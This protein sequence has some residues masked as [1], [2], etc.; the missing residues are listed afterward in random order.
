[1]GVCGTGGWTGPLPGDPDSVATLSAV[2][3]F[4]GVE[5][6]WTM[7]GTNPHAVSYTEV[8]RSTSSNFGDAVLLGTSGGGSYFDRLQNGQTHWYWIRFV[9]INGTTGD[10]IGPA[11][12]MSGLLVDNL[13]AALLGQITSGQFSA[14]I[15]AEMDKIALIQ[16]DLAAEIANRLAAFEALQLVL[17]GLQSE[18]LTYTDLINGE[19]IDRI[20]ADA[21]ILNEV[22]Q[23]IDNAKAITDA[24]IQAVQD[25]INDL[26]G[27][28]GAYDELVTYSIGQTVTYMGS[29]YRAIAE[30]TGNLPTDTAYWQKIGDYA[31]LGEVVAA[32][33][34]TLND[35]ETR[36]EDT[37]DGLVATATSLDALS[38]QVRG[39]YTGNDL[40]AVSAG[41]IFQEREARS[42]AVSTEV[43]AR[44]ALSATITGV[45]NPTGL[46][47]GTLASGLLYDERNARVTADEA[48]VDR[49]D[50]LEATVNNPTTGVVATADALDTVELT[51]NNGTTGVVATA[52]KVSILE[53]KIDNPTVGNNPTYALLV[54]NY[55]S[56][57]DTNSAIA[58]AVN[59]VVANLN[60]AG[61][62]PYTSIAQTRTVAESKSATFTQSST[63]TATKVGDLW[64]DTGN[65][66]ILKR[67]NGSSWVAADDTR[68]GATA[69]SVQQ[70]QAQVGSTDVIALQ[71]QAN[72]NANDIT[73]LEGKYTVKIDANGY[74]TG[75]GLAVNANN[76]TPT[77]EF[78]VKADQFTIAPVQTDNTANDGS[79]FFYR[80]VPTTIN[81]VSV[82]AGA[83]LK[84][85]YIHDASISNAKILN[86]DAA[87]IIAGTLSASQITTGALNGAL[88]AANSIAADRLNVNSLAAISA[89]TGTL[90]VNSSLTVGNGGTR[91]YIRSEGK[92]FA[93]AVNGFI[94]DRLSDGTVRA[95]IGNA[96]GAYFRFNTNGVIEIKSASLN[97]V[98]FEAFSCASPANYSTSTSNGTSVGS[99]R[100]ISPVGGK[101]PYS[102]QWVIT[103]QSYEGQSFSGVI[104]GGTTGSTVTFNASGV[105]A[106][107]SAGIACIIRDANGR[108]ITVQFSY[109]VTWG[110]PP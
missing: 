96:N 28:A 52:N 99:S 109:S 13:L 61:V 66:N 110:S 79:P 14:A 10:L 71:V 17:Q 103:G 59:S 50:L 64:V 42:T 91:G 22:T 107:G 33:S 87:K 54:E 98:S 88:I 58:S 94:F 74:V 106:I 68:I 69:S 77:S 82:P 80:T 70:L 46:T 62:S 27:N 95:E 6:S 97:N 72:V 47:L 38:T 2:G 45:V 15:K 11:S 3:V 25:Q 31:T 34:V 20:D 49:L 84:A 51:V 48:Q 93:S 24:A 7:P 12:A 53:T 35:H 65:G 55:L 81:G 73:G 43:T 40:N 18:L 29:L 67:W 41:L 57:V 30:T 4:G 36:I 105:N 102:Y 37:E 92:D 5:V 85:A 78:I 63:P 44:E 104:L 1:M 9:S 8:Y 75:Y 76:S 100:S 108:T 32:H 101:A 21:D 19:I 83:Y 26:V 90:Y 39:G 56:E 89:V 86:L 16:I 23:Q 60:T